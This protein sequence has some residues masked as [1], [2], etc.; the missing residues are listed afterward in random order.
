MPTLVTLRME[1][2]ADLR[3]LKRL[4][5]EAAS[6]GPDA[7]KVKFSHMKDEVQ[8]HC[9][10]STVSTQSLFRA[11]GAQFPNI[12]SKHLG[13]AHHLY[14]FGMDRI[15]DEGETSTSVASTLDDSSEQI[16]LLQHQIHLLQKQS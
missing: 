10:S 12:E 11:I 3:I 5:T 9:P 6:S 7:K 8:W 2:E 16:A 4:Y 1:T 14:I 15:C 13:K